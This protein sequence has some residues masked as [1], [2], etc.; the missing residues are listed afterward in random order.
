MGLF[1]IYVSIAE[2]KLRSKFCSPQIV[3]LVERLESLTLRKILFFCYF[4]NWKKYVSRELRRFSKEWNY[5]FVDAPVKNLSKQRA[6]N[7]KQMLLRLS[8]VNYIE[9]V[10]KKLHIERK[11]IRENT[12]S[13]FSKFIIHLVVNRTHLGKL[14][15]VKFGRNINFWLFVAPTACNQILQPTSCYVS[16]DEFLSGFIVNIYMEFSL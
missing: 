5:V 7:S 16:F 4:M 15:S 13:T 11:K 8:I 2:F 6:E 9:L 12:T 3:F 1:I 14:L 10:S